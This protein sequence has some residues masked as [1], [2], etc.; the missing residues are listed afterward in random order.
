MSTS[1]EVIA[2]ALQ[3]LSDQ[4][5]GRLS[6]EIVVEAASFPDSPIHGLFT[7][8]DEIAGQRWRLEQAR[9][10]IRSVRVTVTTE[11]KSVTSVFYVR[12]PAAESSEQGYVSLPTLRRDPEGARAAIVAEFSRAASA[13]SRARSVADALG[14]AEQVDDL[15]ARVTSVKEEAAT[16]AAAA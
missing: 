11:E 10:L 1:K 5:G 8:N 16:P 13:L 15:I 4:N 2:Q 7:W 14:M 3:A 9:E 6:A 12:D